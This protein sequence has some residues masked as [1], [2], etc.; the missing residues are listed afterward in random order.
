MSTF[1]DDSGSIPSL[2]KLIGLVAK[3]PYS[4]VFGKDKMQA[5]EGGIG[6]FHILHQD[7]FAF[8]KLDQVGTQEMSLP[9]NTLLQGSLA[10]IHFA[11]KLLILILQLLPAVPGIP[12]IAIDLPF[13]GNG[14]IFSLKGINKRGVIVAAGP[15]PAGQHHRQIKKGVTAEEKLCTLFQVQIDITF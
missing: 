6:D 7:V 15:L 2:L 5:P 4:D 1:S 9:E 8:V 12:A 3:A 13:A 11:D 14:H 10:M